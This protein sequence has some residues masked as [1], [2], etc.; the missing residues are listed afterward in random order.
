M[1]SPDELTAHDLPPY[2]GQE[3][4]AAVLQTDHAEYR[5]LTSD[6]LPGV[7]VLVD[8]R[9]TTDPDKLPGIRRIVIGG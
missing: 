9:R 8:G 6:D 3:L 2:L 7:K 5:S 4:G 1:Y